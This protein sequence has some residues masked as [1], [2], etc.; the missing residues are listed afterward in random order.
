[1]LL[2]DLVHEHT[3]TFFD[4]PR[5]NIMIEKLIPLARDRGCRSLMDY[6][7][8]LKYGDHAEW[9][10]VMDALS[11]QETYFW[12]EM[13]QIRLLVNVF[14]P[15]WFAN[16]QGTLRIW[17]AACATGEE[18]YSVVIALLEAGHG[19]LPI[20]ILATDASGTALKKAQA[21]LYRERSFRTL[22][23]GLREKYFK[24]QGD[25]WQLDQAIVRRVRFDCRNLVVKHDIQSYATSPA[26]LCRNVFIY[27]S[28]E[29]IRR[30]VS[31][32][33]EGMPPNGH[34]MVGAS[35]SLLRLTTDFSLEEING[36]F[37]YVRRNRQS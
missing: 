10:N 27:F 31:W 11:V 37:V 32:F 6:Y 20:E 33:A 1:M 34:L 36:A 21:A 18:P 29:T 17:S 16:N 28:P 30:T 2:R 13:D 22:P 15:K 24:K 23:L 19:H 4:P 5:F 14:V 9:R 25:L 26:I 8:I 3:G 12:R 35:E 7:F